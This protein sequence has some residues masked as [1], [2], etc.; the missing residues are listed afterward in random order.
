MFK[1]T[2]YIDAPV[3]DVWHALINPKTIKLWSG[4]NA[5]MSDE[6]G[7]N[8]KLWNGEIFGKNTKVFK[9][10]QL[11]Q[12]WLQLGWSSPSTV[13]IELLA[14]DN[15]TKINLIHSNFPLTEQKDLEEGW[16]KYYFG[17]IKNLLEG[18]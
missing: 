4:Q 10:K 9:G 15:K 6:V 5:S 18:S 14:K 1:Q 12:D 13:S 2:Y 11:V 16:E 7:F 8:F 3:K 17:A